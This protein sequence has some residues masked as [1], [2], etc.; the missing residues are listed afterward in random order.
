MTLDVFVR[1]PYV[2]LLRIACPLVFNIGN[3]H[4]LAIQGNLTGQID[5]KSK[6]VELKC[7]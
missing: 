4:I 7:H 5:L 2:P 6:V 3:G 1:V